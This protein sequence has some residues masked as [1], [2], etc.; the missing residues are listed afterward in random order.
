MS[1]GRRN[2][3]PGPIQIR[4]R[5]LPAQKQ[6]NASNT[7]VS[8]SGAEEIRTLDLIIANDALYQLSYR[9]L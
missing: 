3:A 1:I 2:Q 8:P 6:K 5:L 7:G 9:P 4:Y